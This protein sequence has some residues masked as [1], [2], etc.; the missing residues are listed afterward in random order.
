M[1]TALYCGKHDILMTEQP[2]PQAGPDDIVVRQ[3]YASICG[4]DVAV[5]QHGPK[6]GHQVTLVKNLV[7][8]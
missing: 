1:K 8:R 6:T 4:T 3:I 7:M 5:Y 2:M